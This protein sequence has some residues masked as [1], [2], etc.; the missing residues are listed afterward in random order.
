MF[1]IVGLGNPGKQYTDTR[2]NVGFMLL[3]KLLNLFEPN[4]QW[5]IQKT[6]KAQT[7]DLKINQ[8]TVKLIKPQTFMNESGY[9]VKTAATFYKISLN[10]LWVVHDD[11]DLPLGA[12]RISNNSS[13]AG[14]RGVQ[15][16]INSLGTQNFKRWRIGIG[17]PTISPTVED[18]VLEPFLPAEQTIIQKS[19]NETIKKIKQTLTDL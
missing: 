4:E 5:R 7:A 12:V 8:L 19:L 15:S 11:L 16:I 2:H 13:A 14:H 17:R 6:F 3:D 18:F 10:H 1:L 9:S